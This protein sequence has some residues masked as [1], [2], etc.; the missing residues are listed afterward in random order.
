MP[1]VP[2]RYSPAVAVT[3]KPPWLL[4]EVYDIY[5]LS[6]GVMGDTL[7]GGEQR[8]TSFGGKYYW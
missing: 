6:Y 8:A 1:I 5:E 4:R 2:C 3:L 7:R